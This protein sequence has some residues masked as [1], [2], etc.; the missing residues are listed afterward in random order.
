VR[1]GLALALPAAFALSLLLAGTVADGA[2]GGPTL[3]GRS[4]QG[5]AVS[6]RPARRSGART[7]SHKVRL[8]CSDGT[9]FTEGRFR[10]DVRPVRG[11]FR[12]S[13]TSSRGAVR[14]TVAGSATSTR[15]AGTIVVTERF[16]ASLNRDGSSPSDPRGTVTCR[17]GTVRW[18]VR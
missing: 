5:L 16:R 15:A 11:S 4:A 12:L 13:V 18:S 1:R 3:H 6:L 2:P 17:S 7:F 14:T 10:D 8:D 9:S